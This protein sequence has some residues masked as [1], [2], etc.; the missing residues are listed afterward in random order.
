[1][2]NERERYERA[3]QQFEMPEPA[4]D[5]LNRRRDRKRRDQ[6]IRAGILGLAIAI[7]VG[8]LSVN[9]IRSMPPVPTDDPTPTPAPVG[10]GALA[11]ALDGDIYVADWDGSNAVRIADGRE[12]CGAIG[13]YWAEGPIWSPDGRYLAYRDSDCDRRQDAWWDVVISDAQGNVVTSFPSE[14]WRISW[15]PD[16]TRVAVWD[17]WLDDDGQEPSTIGV[18]GIDGERQLLTMPPGWQPSGDYDPVWMPDGTSLMVNTV[19]LPLD[20]GAPRHL[21]WG[22]EAFSPDGSH[23][24]Y[25][26]RVSRSL[27]V[28]RSDGSEP[29]EVFGEGAQDL[30]WSPTGDRI[31]FTS[32]HSTELRLLD[33]ATGT[34]TL[35]TEMDGSD[36]LMYM[37][38]GAFDFSPEGD[39]I[40]FSRTE[41]DGAGAS[42]LWSIDVDGSDLRRLVTGTAW[43]DWWSPTQTP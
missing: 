6:R 40:L 4:W 22:P 33:V 18:Y 31:A 36:E 27:M 5:R 20:G 8:W 9:A 34:V 25:V 15:S 29:R 41:D 43:G 16:S 7:A 42:S 17:L 1:M 23:I 12:D 13:E 21:P 30:A 38:G 39:R 14:G 26:S 19:E 10:L 28:A 37:A 32:G 3:F 2:I 11:Y 35:L 24:A